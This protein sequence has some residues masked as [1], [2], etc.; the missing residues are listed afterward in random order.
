LGGIANIVST[1]SRA[2]SALGMVKRMVAVATGSRRHGRHGR[3]KRRQPQQRGAKDIGLDLPQHEVVANFLASSTELPIDVVNERMPPEHRARDTLQKCKQ[4]IS[5]Q[6]V[7]P[8]MNQYL[9]QFASREDFKVAG[10]NENPGLQD[11][12]HHRP[13]NFSRCR[14]SG[15]AGR[16]QLLCRGGNDS[17]LH[18]EV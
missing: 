17:A 11:S 3:G 5:P 13:G 16:P 10:W 18:R 12:D 9:Q 6:R 15:E 7:R 14:I 2:L 4:K 8:F 1:N